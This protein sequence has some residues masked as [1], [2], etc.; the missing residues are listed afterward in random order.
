MQRIVSLSPLFFLASITLNKKWKTKWT[1]AK[2]NKF[3]SCSFYILH[4]LSFLALK[5][6]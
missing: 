6:K 1:L 5:N 2:E 3:F 4:R